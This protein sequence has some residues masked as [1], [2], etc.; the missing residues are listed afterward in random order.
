MGAQ[1]RDDPLASLPFS[2]LG[3]FLLI[4]GTYLIG[5]CGWI[6]PSFHQLPNNRLALLRYGLFRDLDA[7]LSG[8]DGR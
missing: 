4:S 7:Q 5:R 1:V 8:G 6:Q 2:G 3:E